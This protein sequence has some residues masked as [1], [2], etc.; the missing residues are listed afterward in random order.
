MKFAKYLLIWVSQNLAVPFWTIGHIHLM[1]TVYDDITEII[2][3]VG[4]NIIVV[5]GIIVDYRDKKRDDSERKKD[6]DDIPICFI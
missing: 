5:A 6:D 2:S 3:S 4:M 1:T